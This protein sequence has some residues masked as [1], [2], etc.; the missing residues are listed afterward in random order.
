MRISIIMLA[1]LAVGSLVSCNGNNAATSDSVNADSTATAQAPTDTILSARIEAE[2]ASMPIKK[3]RT[4]MTIESATYDGNQLVY[5]AVL[6]KGINPEKNKGGYLSTDNGYVE[7]WQPSLILNDLH[8]YN[9]DIVNRLIELNQSMVFNIKSS[10]DTDYKYTITLT[11]A[12]MQSKLQGT[13]LP[14]GSQVKDTAL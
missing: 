10:A 13:P 11:A 2:I 14:D 9:Q 7:E 1:V 6:D 12:D 3:S 8:T 4:F 5:N